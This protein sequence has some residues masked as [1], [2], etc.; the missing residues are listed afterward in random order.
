MMRTRLCGLVLLVLF[1]T[2][3]LASPAFAS[4]HPWDGTKVTDTLI[5]SSGDLGQNPDV[6]NGDDDSNG[7]IFS[8]I[9]K[10]LSDRFTTKNGISRAKQGIKQEVKQTT[11]RKSMNLFHK[12][13]YKH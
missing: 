5:T 11:G 8:L 12:N 7:G 2:V 13:V 3:F 6:P 10:W 4:E 1:L 9:I